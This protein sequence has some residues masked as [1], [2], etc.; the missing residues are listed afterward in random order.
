MALSADFS[1][2]SVTTTT[3]ANFIPEIWTDGIKAY[4]ERNLVFEQCVDTSLNGLVKGRGDV[5]HIPKLAEVS[6]AAKAAETLVTYAVSTHAKSDLTIDQHRYAAKL[7]EDIASVQSI[8]G[9]FE[10]EV[11]G[12]AYA[13]AKTYDAYIES[14]VEAA[15]TNSTALAGDNTIT[16]AEIRGGMKTLMEADVDTNQCHFVVSPALYTAM[17]GI[18]DFVDASKLGAGPSGLKNGQI[19]MLYGMPVLHSTVMG[20]SGSTGVEVGYIFHPSAVSAARQLE[21]RVQAEYSVDFLGT[22]VVSDML[23]GAVTVFE[24]R[25]QEF[26]N[27]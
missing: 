26:K 19:G 13:L 2:A 7:V 5:F 14:M 17:L 21:P 6:D 1:G 16:A 27:P 10:K 15:T 20:S 12:M 18:S 11:S 8:P 22:K 9:L 25:I 4:L 3:A 23:Y 24:G